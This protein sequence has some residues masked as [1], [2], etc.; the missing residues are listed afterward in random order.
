[1]QYTEYVSKGPVVKGWRL[2]AAC[3]LTFGLVLLCAGVG[4]ADTFAEH[5]A[6]LHVG[7]YATIEGQVV[8]VSVSEKGTIFLNFGAPYPDQLFYAVV[9]ASNADQ[10]A[11]VRDLEG[12]VVAVT[13]TIGLYHGRPQ[14]IVSSP[15][16]IEAR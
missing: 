15:E 10:F 13:G 12:Q 14:I 16:Q 3:A 5:E 1:M 8:Q 11:G 6:A 4:K 2:L 9:F 7:E